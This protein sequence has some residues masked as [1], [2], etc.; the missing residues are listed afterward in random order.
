MGDTRELE[1]AG[2]GDGRCPT[3]EVLTIDAGLTE[4]RCDDCRHYYD[5]DATEPGR[6]P[7]PDDGL[8]RPLGDPGE[9]GHGNAA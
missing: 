3:G 1:C 5:L 6:R 9:A 2:P 7:Q 8:T 4:Y